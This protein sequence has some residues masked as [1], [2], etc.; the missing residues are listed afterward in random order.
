MAVRKQFL[1][2]ARRSGLADRMIESLK[3]SAL[4]VANIPPPMSLHQI[5]LAKNAIDVAI[6][7]SNKRMAV[8]S[9]NDVSIYAFDIHKKPIPA[10]S[11]LWR[12]AI[13]RHH[14]S[15]QVAFKG[16]TDVLVLTNKWEG[17]ES[18]L[19]RCREEKVELQE[20]IEGFGCISNLF[21]GIK[22]SKLYLQSVQGSVLE[23]VTKDDFSNTAKELQFRLI[24]KFPSPTP[25]VQVACYANNVLP[26]FFSV[27]LK[28]DVF[29]RPSALDSLPAALC[30][31]MNVHSLETARHSWLQARI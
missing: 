3:L 13:P 17:G 16:D 15:R 30:M 5:D 25:W 7:A 4:R 31:P 21:P 22:G 20:R 19:W 2:L 10:P 23:V 27:Y 11:V 26:I 1:Q 24:A 14:C 12:S 8:L 9:E 29:Y 28:A 6:S 18:A